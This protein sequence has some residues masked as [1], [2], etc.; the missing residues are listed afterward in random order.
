GVQASWEHGADGLR[1]VPGVHDLRTGGRRGDFQGDRWPFP[2]GRGQLYRH[3]RR[4]LERRLRGD[5]RPGARGRPRRRRPCHQGPLSYG[6][7]P[8]RRRPLAQTRS[9]GV[10]GQPQASRHGLHRPLPG[11]LLGRCDPAGRD[12]LRPHRPR[13]E[14][15]GPLHRRL[16]LHGLAAHEE[17]RC[18]RGRRLREVRVPAAAV[19][20][21]GAK[22]RA[23]GFARL[24]GGGAGCDP[25]E[26]PWRR[27]PLREVQARRGAARGLAHRWRR[28][29]YGGV[30]GP[31]RHGAQLGHARRGWQDLRGDRQELRPDL[32]KLAPQARRHDRPDHRRPH[33]GTTGRQPRRERLGT[34]RRS[35]RGPLHSE[36]PRRRLPVPFYPQRPT[37]V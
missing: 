20:A 4:L 26:P 15:Q 30:L 32:S 28:G 3:R 21:R 27:L 2:R 7:G 5:H 37:G 36:R 34:D 16:Q 10:R 22:H 31:P 17:P 14:R 6:R 9:A 19:L 35:G 29:V 23:G 11:S 8:E 13:Q 18:Q 33:P 25:L 24:R 1:A 12:P